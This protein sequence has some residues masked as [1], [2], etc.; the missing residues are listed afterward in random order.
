VIVAVS[1]I[2]YLFI[3]IFIGYSA[4]KRIQT[5]EDFAVA[6]RR[7]P[8]FMATAAFFATWF[9]SETILG[10]TDEFLDEGVL[11]IIEEPLGAALCLILVGIFYA[12]KIYSSGAITFSDLFR[13]KLG[14]K[15]ELVSAIV[16]IPSF[17]TWIAAQFLALG[18]IF[19]VL[20]G[21]P[22]W[23]GILIGALLVMVY[24]AIGG[25][26]AVSM[27]DSLQMI[28]IISGL[29]IVLLFLFFEMGTKE[30]QIEK[31]SIPLEIFNSKRMSFLDWLAAWFTVGLGAIAS[32]DI[33]QR[34]VASKNEKVAVS[35]SLFS[36]ILYLVIG[37]IPLLIV[38]L[39]QLVYPDI[40]KR[41]PE[42]FITSL[43]TF[44]MPVWVQVLFFGSLI[45]AILSTASGALLA[46]ATV[47][48]E[49]VLKPLKIGKDL[50]YNMRISVI[51]LAI[52][53]VLLAF[54]NQSVFELVSIAS[55]FG[56]VSLFIPFSFLL[57]T[58]WVKESGAVIGML[59]GLLVWLIA[60]NLSL[61]I[62]SIFYGMTASFLGLFAG[63]YFN[64]G[65]K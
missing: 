44:K 40:Y 4:S 12:R 33:F 42:N 50:L 26:W 60:E 38:L 28:V 8:M 46:P 21:T 5:A 25:M 47:L 13:D 11:G 45:S 63:N 1:V 61:E 27:T 9:G 53:S 24:T 16:M 37:V 41:Y 54:N 43:I 3:T 30:I 64:F 57:F 20:F 51:V 58:G 29:I 39:G 56:L 35:S 23:L 62:P 19:E 15:A 31:S 32:Q 22:L 65:R 48:A 14:T 6:G 52:L 36:G 2:A 17:F 55:S 18:L 59:S 34:V 49:N 7:L 10:A